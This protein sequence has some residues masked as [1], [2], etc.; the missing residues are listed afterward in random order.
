MLR[1]GREKELFRLHGVSECLI[2][3]RINRFTVEVLVGGRGAR[4]SLNNTGR[5]EEFM[6]GRGYCLP[7]SGA[8]PYRLFA[9]RGGSVID[10]LL[11]ARAFEEALSRNLLP[12][13]RNYRRKRR[14]VRLGSSLLDYE[15]ARNGETL[16]LEL[17]SAVLRSGDLALYP[18]CPTERGR[19]HVRELIEF[20]RRGGKGMIFF[21]TSLRGVRGIAPNQ[22]AD[23]ELYRLMEE[24]RREGVLMGGAN[25]LFLP[26][27]S[28]V[29]LLHPDLPVETTT[30][31]FPSS[32]RDP[33]STGGRRWPP[34]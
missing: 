29:V 3:R 5:L 11:Q 18:D 17:K 25:I 15:L 4:A 28:R 21:M 30:P 31:G 23:P 24:A 8:L 10:T 1:E 34:P 20:S 14:N 9:V 27:S 7:G 13:L 22:R 33:R 2:L 12:S 19:K 16:L 32:P 6:G 26:R